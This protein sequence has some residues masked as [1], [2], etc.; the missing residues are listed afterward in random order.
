MIDTCLKVLPR[1]ALASADSGAHRILLSQMWNCDGPR[2]LLQSSGLCTMGCALPL[3]IGAKR[4]APERAVV[5]FM[6]DAGFLMVAGELAS[7]AALGLPGGQPQITQFDWPIH[8]NRQLELGEEAAR[9]AVAG[10]V[11]RRLEQF[12]CKGLVL[13]GGACV[14]RVAVAEIVTPVVQTLGSLEILA[15]PAL[16]TRVWQDLAPLVK[17][18]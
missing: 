10:F 1:G 6:G 9:A 3:A 5:G 15:R 18:S 7:A 17:F 2:T 16:K 13:L 12:R 11:G 14:E 8:T 4:A